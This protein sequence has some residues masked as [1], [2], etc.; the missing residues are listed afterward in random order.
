MHYKLYVLHHSSFA[1]IRFKFD[2]I[3]HYENIQPRDGILPFGQSGKQNIR[4]ILV[5][6]LDPGKPEIFPFN[7]LTAIERC[8]LHHAVSN[9]IMRESSRD[10]DLSCEEIGQKLTGN[11]YVRIIYIFMRKFM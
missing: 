11:I 5:K 7:A 4:N 10:T 1:C 6:T 9:T 3:E 2:G 8:T